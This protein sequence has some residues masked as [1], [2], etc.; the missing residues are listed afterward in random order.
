MMYLFSGK[1]HLMLDGC[2]DKRQV[3][4][5]VIAAAYGNNSQITTFNFAE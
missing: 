1:W 4:L 3:H 2:E 5:G